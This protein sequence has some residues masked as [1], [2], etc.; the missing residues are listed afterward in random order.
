MSEKKDRAELLRNFTDA[1]LALTCEGLS[2]LT[3][4]QALQVGRAQQLGGDIVLIFCPAAGN[5]TVAMHMEGSDIDPVP[6]FKILVPLPE[7][8][9]N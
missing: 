6:L 8:V 5:V 1:A 7:A 9:T 2:G 4:A 3:P